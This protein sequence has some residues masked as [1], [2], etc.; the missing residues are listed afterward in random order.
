MNPRVIEAV[1]EKI[2][3]VL[4]RI[5]NDEQAEAIARAAI[6]ANVDSLPGCD[7]DFPELVQIGDYFIPR[8]EVRTALLE[9]P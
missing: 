4:S 3:V 6:E 9:A 5:V 8:G 1:M 7:S 2:A